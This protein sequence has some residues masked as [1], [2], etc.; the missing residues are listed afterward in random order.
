MYYDKEGLPITAMSWALLMESATYRIIKQDEAKNKNW[1]STVWLGL[2]HSH[3]KG[4]RLIF[5]TMVF[6]SEDDS[7]V[8]SCRRYAT[9]KKARVGH[10]EMLAEAD[11]AP[12]HHLRMLEP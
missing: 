1:V 8:L 2:D 6:R 4:E 9:E 12:R 7:T 3:K 5:E 11:A 10:E